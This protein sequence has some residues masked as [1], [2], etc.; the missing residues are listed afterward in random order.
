MQQFIRDLA[1]GQILLL[2]N[3]LDCLDD[4]RLQL[5]YL[6]DGIDLWTARSIGPAS[7]CGLWFCSLTW[8]VIVL[9]CLMGG[10][11]FTKVAAWRGWKDLP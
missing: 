7:M 11:G 6:R 10:L 1:F 9:G 3:H 2:S 8:H 5:V 4:P